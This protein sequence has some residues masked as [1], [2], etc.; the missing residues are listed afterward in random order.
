MNW[1]EEQPCFEGVATEL[2]LCY[3]DLSAHYTHTTRR[4]SEGEEEG[5]GEGEEAGEGEG[6][7]EGEM[8]PVS[9]RY[10][11]LLQVRGFVSI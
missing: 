8:G 4:H 5:E 1:E 2:G 6:E 3:S 11:Y 7:E 9:K 10:E